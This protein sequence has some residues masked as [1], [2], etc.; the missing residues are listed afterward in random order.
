MRLKYEQDE[1]PRASDHTPNV[2]RQRPFFFQAG[3]ETRSRNS[4]WI[5]MRRRKGVNSHAKKL[6]RLEER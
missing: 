6:P 1:H 5:G 2:F 4:G 3:E